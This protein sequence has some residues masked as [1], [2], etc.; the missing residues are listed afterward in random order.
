MANTNALEILPVAEPP[1][2]RSLLTRLPL[3]AFA[4]A[5][6]G[7]VFGLA[8]YAAVTG[9]A[10][11]GSGHTGLVGLVLL[12]IVLLA[13]LGV[14]IAWR[15]LQLWARRRSA[16]ARLQIRLV[17]QFAVVAIVPAVLIA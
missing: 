3:F 17:G 15:L 5:G 7:A 8:S 4:I 16:G 12:N 14:M 11:F 1:K 13:G 9:I 10:P 2:L 6:I